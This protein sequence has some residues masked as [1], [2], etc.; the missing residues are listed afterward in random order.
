MHLILLKI[1]RLSIKEKTFSLDIWE[2]FKRRYGES[3]AHQLV[4]ALAKPVR[5][6]S[7]RV[8]LLKTSKEELSEFLINEGW[9]VQIHSQLSMA[10][11][12]K[13]KGP[14]AIT[15]YQKS[16]RIVIDKIAAESVFVGANLFSAGLVRLPKFRVN[17]LVSLVSPKDQIVANGIAQTDSKQPKGKGIAVKT[18][19]SFYSVPS[20]RELGLFNKGLANSQSI[21]AM[22]VTHLLEPKAGERIID[23]CAA[24]GGK[25]TA[26][27]ILAKDK[28]EIIAIDR[29]KKRLAKMQQVIANHGIRN[30]RLIRANSVELVKNQTIKADKVIVDPSCTAIGVR[31]KIYDETTFDDILNS[32]SYQKSFIWAAAKVARK[33]GIIT[34]S[35]CTTEPEENEKVIAYAVNKLGL[36]LIEPTLKLGANGEDTGDGLELEAMRRFYPD[37]FD[38]PGFFVAKLMK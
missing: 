26:A 9:D 33:G 35:T 14:K 12:V 16:P 13:T 31:P 22:Y 32:A 30:I 20:L 28:A 17:D 8:N 24:P 34:Y 21:P 27:A 38:T 36:K 5:L 4:H 23:L 10:L 29:S 3:R 15:Y 37:T 25:S 11:T 6:Y 19:E 2:R 18:T 7:I 1:P